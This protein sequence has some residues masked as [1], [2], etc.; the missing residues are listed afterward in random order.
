MLVEI[1]FSHGGLSA[2][3]T[4]KFIAIEKFQISLEKQGGRGRTY[5]T[6]KP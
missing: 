4:N 2:F 6:H 3:V 1:S 5:Y